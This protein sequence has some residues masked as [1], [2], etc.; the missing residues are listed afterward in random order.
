MGEIDLAGILVF[1]LFQAAA[2]AT[3]AQALPFGAGH[4]FQRLGFP[5][6]SL[7]ARGRL[8]RCGHASRRV[9]Q[10]AVRP[11]L[12]PWRQSCKWGCSRHRKSPRAA[13]ALWIKIASPPLVCG[14]CS[15]RTTVSPQRRK[16]ALGSPQHS[17]KTSQGA[18]WGLEALS[19]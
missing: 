12:R 3:V 19:D 5:E 6:E 16:S 15:D 18:L 11:F 13:L 2:R 9:G 8:G 4:L 14:S 17:R 10:R 1:E 7:L